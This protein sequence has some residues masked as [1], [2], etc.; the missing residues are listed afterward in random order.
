MSEDQTD[1]VNT[2]DVQIEKN[3]DHVFETVHTVHEQLKAIEKFVARRFDE[4]SMEINATSQQMDMNEEDINKKFSEIFQVVKEISFS[5]DGSTAANTGVELDAV[6]KMTNE[7]ANKILDAADGIS[8]SINIDDAAWANPDSRK[9]ALKKIENHISDIIMAC[10]FQDLTGQRINKTLEGIQS[11]ESRL[12]DTL[13]K[14]GVNVDRAELE[15]EEKSGESTKSGATQ[16]EID[17][18]FG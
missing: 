10:S 16:D 3:A 9:Y 1:T 7:A 18:L 6:V 11:I 14:M 13:K 5:G 12:E 17:E 2:D 15:A 4:I 8:D